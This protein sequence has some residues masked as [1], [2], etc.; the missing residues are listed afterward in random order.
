[1]FGLCY[2]TA[3]QRVTGLRLCTAGSFRKVSVKAFP[4]ATKPQASVSSA[5]SWHR[6]PP[7]VPCH[8]SPNKPFK[9]DCLRQP[10]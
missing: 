2:S 7:R 10:V 6:A 8:Q 3:Q 5:L 4:L 1:V 9:P